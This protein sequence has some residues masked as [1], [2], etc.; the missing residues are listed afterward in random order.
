MKTETM[1][2]NQLFNKVSEF[3]RGVLTKEKALKL[4]EFEYNTIPEIIE[5][6]QI[7][8]DRYISTLGY[9]DYCNADAFTFMKELQESGLVNMFASVPNIQAGLHL[10]RKEAT[11]LLKIYMKDYIKIYNPEDLL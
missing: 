5:S 11:T 7:L 4:Y 9:P 10:N 1:T 3:Y 6:E 2:V 8:S